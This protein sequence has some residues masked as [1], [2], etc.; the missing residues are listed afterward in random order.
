MHTRLMFSATGL[1]DSDWTQRLESSSNTS[2]KVRTTPN[3]IHLDGSCVT[4]KGGE[5]RYQVSRC[6]VPNAIQTT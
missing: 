3:A 2:E 1:D 5:Q 4:D 6:H